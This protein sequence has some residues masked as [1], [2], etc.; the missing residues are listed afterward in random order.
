MVTASQLQ[1]NSAS[2][3]KYAMAGSDY[4]ALANENNTQQQQG[5][6]LTS[7]EQYRQRKGLSTEKASSAQPVQAVAAAQPAATQNNNASA[8]QAAQSAVQIN[9]TSGLPQGETFR[10]TLSHAQQ[11]QF[12]RENQSK[13]SQGKAALTE[14]QFRQNIGMDTSTVGG[15]YTAPKV[16]N[17]SYTAATPATSTK[18]VGSTNKAATGSG[19]QK[20]AAQKAASSANSNASAVSGTAQQAQAQTISAN[21]TARRNAAVKA[22]NDRITAQAK[23]DAQNAAN[24]KRSAAQEAAAKEKA[25]A[26]AKVEASKTANASV[27]AA[28]LKRSK[29]LQSQADDAKKAAK[30]AE[31]DADAKAKLANVYGEASYYSEIAARTGN[32]AAARKAAVAV[33]GIKSVKAE[34][35]KTEAKATAA[36]VTDHNGEILLSNGT[37]I[38]RV[39]S[40]GGRGSGEGSISIRTAD[41]TA[42]EKKAVSDAYEARKKS[43]KT[44]KQPSAQ[45]G[46]TDYHAVGWSVLNK[47]DQKQLQSVLKA[48]EEAKKINPNGSEEYFAGVANVARR[49]QMS[50][51]EVM[52]E[53]S[54]RVNKQTAKALTPVFSAIDRV[55]KA[56]DAALANTSIVLSEKG[57]VQIAKKGKET[58]KGTKF[59]A[60]ETKDKAV[61]GNV[62]LSGFDKFVDSEYES[63]RTKPVSYVAGLGA[64]YVAG[65]ALG[66]AAGGAKLLTEAGG[67]KV[68]SKFVKPTAKKAAELA[69]KHVIDAAML[70]GLV[71][72]TGHSAYSYF[73]DPNYKALSGIDRDIAQ[74]NFA[75]EMFS[76]GKD[77]LVG[78]IGFKKGAN[79][80]A[81]TYA[82]V[83]AMK[84]TGTKINGEI[85][86]VSPDR[87]TIETNAEG[88]LIQKVYPT[89]IAIEATAKNAQKTPK[90]KTVKV[91]ELDSE[92]NTATKRYEV[93]TKTEKVQNALGK[94]KTNAVKKV[95]T[96]LETTRK[97][98]SAKVEAAKKPSTPVRNVVLSVD[99][100]GKVR[101]STKAT[102][103]EQVTKKLTALSKNLSNTVKAA[104][105][106]DKRAKI[107]LKVDNDGD[108]ISAP[109][110]ESASGL[111]NALGKSLSTLKRSVSKAGNSLKSR[112]VYEITIKSDAEGELYFT[113]KPAR[114]GLKTFRDFMA[115]ESAVF[116]P[117]KASEIRVAGSDRY[118]G[119]SV[120]KA[121][122]TLKKGVFEDISRIEALTKKVETK[123]VPPQYREITSKNGQVTLLREAT[124]TEGV[125]KVDTRRVVN[126]R[127]DLLVPKKT[128]VKVKQMGK[129][130]ESRGRKQVTIPRLKAIKAV[131]TQKMIMAVGGI[132][133]VSGRMLVTPSLQQRGGTSNPVFVPVHKVET[134]VKN[135]EN[136]VRKLDVIIKP[137]VTVK[138]AV[139]V[140]PAVVNPQ[141]I[142]PT[143]IPA[144]AV[145]PTQTV[146][147]VITVKPAIITPPVID[148]V[149]KPIIDQIQKIEEITAVSVAEHRVPP[150]ILENKAI[151]AKKRK[152]EQ[153]GKDKRPKGIVKLNRELRNKLGSLQSMFDA[154]TKKVATKKAATKR[155]IKRVSRA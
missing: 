24:A 41:L 92:G 117:L 69:G 8:A 108:L 80:V 13:V 93:I 138:P 27:K 155:S 150:I 30:A 90:G 54:A 63:L 98:I 66:A 36:G 81:S 123:P 121:K 95:S 72:S 83:K 1:N 148:S 46:E 115:D 102:V 20:I 25:A 141:K 47:T 135:I 10:Y 56:A 14:L 84:P 104:T 96:K 71:V 103:T 112:K 29:E 77:F 134:V 38:S 68:A 87:L 28:A 31:D 89:K 18:D 132:H 97:T 120:I 110:V 122:Q 2:N 11:N 6:A 51:T 7:E 100:N 106:K 124:K 127:S 79:E 21:E 129:V 114:V 26:V 143:V 60:K 147:P 22:E 57:T 59:N 111:R 61:A 125:A 43:G 142:I 45:T 107:T 149:L 78:G 73:T 48:L 55:A 65:S 101:V 52:A 76:T 32:A 35:Q 140:K 9:K 137:A 109:V 50:T 86:K 74:A 3:Y 133:P 58:L 40:K 4:K 64:T 139:I 42:S 53:D 113:A 39:E 5:K 136:T 151:Y 152:P 37:W 145:I 88:E 75:A 144:Q 12:V 126:L 70:G 33:K 91:T 85:R 105:T 23:I 94:V 154:P 49:S 19:D 16:T 34:V 67:A 44:V 146:P 131:R 82:R 153:E 116:R 128:K 118:I 119:A 15:T 130:A 62:V 17:N 99:T